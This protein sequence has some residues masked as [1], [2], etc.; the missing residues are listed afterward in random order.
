MSFKN[1]LRESKIISHYK[2]KKFKRKRLDKT[3]TKS[4]QKCSDFSKISTKP[5]L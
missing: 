1:D 5:E 3:Q 2:P 4:R